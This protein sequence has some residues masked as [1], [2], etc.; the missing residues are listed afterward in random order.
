MHSPFSFLN[1]AFFSFILLSIHYLWGLDNKI[2][3]EDVN[4]GSGKF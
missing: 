2:H 1:A 4:L 3:S